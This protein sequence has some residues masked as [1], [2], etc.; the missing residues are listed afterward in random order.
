MSNKI[1]VPKL[2][3][4][5]LIEVEEICSKKIAK[6]YTSINHW[7][8]SKYFVNVIN[9]ARKHLSAHLAIAKN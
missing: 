6:S 2:A 3:M 8:K 7:L 1:C 5:G 4:H 9:S